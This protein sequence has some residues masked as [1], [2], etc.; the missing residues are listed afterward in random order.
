MGST[1]AGATL[2]LENAVGKKAPILDQ[3][4]YDSDSFDSLVEKQ[5]I[6]FEDR[7]S[8]DKQF[9]EL[10]ITNSKMLGE[11]LRDETK[12]AQNDRLRALRGKLFDAEIDFFSQQ[13]P[14]Q[15]LREHYGRIIDAGLFNVGNVSKEIEN[16][17]NRYESGIIEGVQST[18]L[19][20]RV[21]YGK[22]R[23]AASTDS[24]GTIGDA[25]IAR[26]DI[27][28][29]RFSVFKFGN[30]SVGGNGKTMS[31]F[32]RQDQL[33]RIGAI[34]PKTNQYVS[35]EKTASLDDF[36]S[37]EQIFDAFKTVS[38]QFDDA[39][40][41]GYS[42]QYSIVRIHG[43][44]CDF[45]LA[46]ARTLL[47]AYVFGETGETSKRARICRYDDKVEREVVYQT[48]GNTFQF[49]NA[50]DRP[51]MLKNVGFVTEYQT[52]KP[53]RDLAVGER[54]TP[55]MPL[56]MEHKTVDACIPVITHLP[57]WTSL[58]ED[59]TNELGS[60]DFLHHNL[61]DYLSLMATDSTGRI[62]DV[63]GVGIGKKPSDVKYVRMI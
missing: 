39:I 18:L 1:I 12:L 38:A 54:V 16:H 50:V 32:I 15:F 47:T 41:N 31:G 27:P 20:G 29:N 6:A 34:S 51:L 11:A 48:D 8:H 5:R 35:F 53:Y 26:D 30:T 36:L 46:E 57:S 22:N 4:L 55:G 28:Y 61:N 23:T 58:N 33:S 56:L 25:S 52:I 62:R 63:V 59:G 9:R 13:N 17:L 24:F 19:S 3:V 43:I 45:N 2:S 37:P 44:D 14:A 10:G 7:L 21:K 60:G 49:H 42:L 40:K